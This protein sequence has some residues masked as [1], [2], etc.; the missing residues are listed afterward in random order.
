M[1]PLLPQ[2]FGVNDDIAL[3]KKDLYHDLFNK[4]PHIYKSAENFTGICKVFTNIFQYLYDI[5]RSICNIPNWNSDTD[6]PEGVY[7]RM[8]ARLMCVD[9]ND[10]DTDQQIYTKLKIKACIINSRGRPKD[11]FNY[12]STAGVLPAS[13]EPITYIG[14]ATITVTV[15]ADTDFSPPALYSQYDYVV[16]DLQQIKG[17]GIKIEVIPQNPKVFCLSGENGYAA[18]GAG[19]GVILENG[20]VIGGGFF[21]LN[22]DDLR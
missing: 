8:A 6:P 18:N 20:S 14:N 19:F 1:T 2:D 15:N 17:A 10:S 21:S 16:G 13:I 11:F 5:I 4:L 12:L 9:Y 3:Q 7:L 22:G